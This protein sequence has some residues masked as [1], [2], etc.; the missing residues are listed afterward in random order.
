M[1]IINTLLGF[2]TVQIADVLNRSKGSPASPRPFDIVFFWKDN[3]IKIL[4]SIS[5]STVLA[6]TAHLNFEAFIGAVWDG[7]AEGLI[8]WAIGAVP[9]FILQ[10]LKKSLGI[11][12]PPEVETKNGKFERL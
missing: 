9:E 12:Q 11:A 6:I 1:F 7:N 3:W 4:L 2:L 8:Y 5:L 10:R